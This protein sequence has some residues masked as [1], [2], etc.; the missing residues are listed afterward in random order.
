LKFFYDLGINGPEFDSSWNI[1][2]GYEFFS[3]ITYLIKIKQD[4][5]EIV[6][7]T[8]PSKNLSYKLVTA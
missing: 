4:L 2:S 5:I 6:E 8:S 3:G 7:S 1:N